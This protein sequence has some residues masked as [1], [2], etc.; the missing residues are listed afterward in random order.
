MASAPSAAAESASLVSFERIS[1]RLIGERQSY[2][3]KGIQIQLR[4]RDGE[5]RRECS[6]SLMSGAK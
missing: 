1:R 6:G 3:T 2:A 5:A 4:M